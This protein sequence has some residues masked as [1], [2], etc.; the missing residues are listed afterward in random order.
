MYLP[1]SKF[2]WT[3]HDIEIL[4][5]CIF[6]YKTSM[7]SLSYHP[8]TVVTSWACEHGVGDFGAAK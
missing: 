1:S 6:H 4:I 2:V 5:Q 7:F 8:Q 3:S